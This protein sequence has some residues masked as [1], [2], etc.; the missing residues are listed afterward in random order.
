MSNLSFPS[1]QAESLGQLGSAFINDTSAHTGQ[2]GIIQCI[3]ACTFTTLTSGNG[4]N[5]SPLMSGTLSSVTMAAGM[6]I[7]G[8]FTA[9]TLATG[10]VIAYNAPAA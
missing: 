7:Y 10:S 4:N 6:I 3:A 5:G 8:Y 9:I 2:W 1:P